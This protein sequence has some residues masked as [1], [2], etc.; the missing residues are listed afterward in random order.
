MPLGDLEREVMTQLWGSAE[1]LSVR[2][3]HER[4]RAR[5]LAYTT[6]MTVLDRLAKKGVVTRERDGRAWLYAPVQTREQMTAGVML[7][8]LS[9]TRA[10]VRG[11][12]RTSLDDEIANAT[13]VL[14]SADID[15]RTSVRAAR[16]NT[17]SGRKAVNASR[18]GPASRMSCLSSSMVP[19]IRSR[20]DAVPVLRSSTTVTALWSSSACGGALLPIDLQVANSG[21]S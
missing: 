12:R 5:D 15:A 13:R 9:D 16:W 18:N 3:V 8:A 20:L 17:R 19:A 7:D 2:Q 10:V 11:Y 14:A 1:P 6:V 4:L 21:R